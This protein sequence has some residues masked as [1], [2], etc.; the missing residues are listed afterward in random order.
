MGDTVARHRRWHAAAVIVIAGSVAGCAGGPSSPAPVFLKGSSPGA[1]QESAL[2]PPPLPPEWRTERPPATKAM[3][4]PARPAGPERHIVVRR[5]QSVGGL[6]RDYH[7][8]KHAIIAANH[9]QPPFKIEIGQKLLIPA[10]GSAAPVVRE[11]ALR[12]PEPH[13]IALREPAAHE[14][15]PHASAHRETSLASPAKAGRRAP[16]V[17]PLDGP[18]AQRSSTRA[19]KAAASRETPLDPERAAPREQHADEGEPASGP[20]LPHGGRMPWPVSGRI[21]ASYGA[22][23]GGGRN[24]GINIAAPRGAPVKAVE[25]GVVAYAGNEVRGYGN[26]VLIKHPDGFITAYAH[27]EELLVK[28]GEHVKSGEVIAKVGAT[29]GVGQPQLHFELRRGERAI[30]PRKF[31]APRA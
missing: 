16:E 5:G 28:R 20:T 27:C 13:Q 8:T 24:D 15:E 3:T 17:I 4:T 7:V 25:G 30:D 14:P 18:T 26:L 31:L 6:A 22:E 19:A 10:P 11:A 2:G 23:P 21:L 12:E 29:G 9:L 1:V